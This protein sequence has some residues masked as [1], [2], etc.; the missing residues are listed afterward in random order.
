MAS[1]PGLDRRKIVNWLLAVTGASTVGSVLY[2]IFRFLTPPEVVEATTT[3]V[4][5]AT[6]DELPVNGWKIFRFGT[7]PGIIIRISE[8]EFRAFAAT[9]THLDCI[10][11]YRDDKR[12][13]WCACHNGLFD[14]SGRNVSGPPPRPL[15]TYRVNV[16]GDKVYASKT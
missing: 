4:E 9:C 15:E 5:A 10:V 16:V 6:L 11:Q 2:P 14:L 8:S 1:G 7:R 13:I 3:T 12:M